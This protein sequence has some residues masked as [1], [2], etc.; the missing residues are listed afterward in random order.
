MEKVV[1]YEQRRRIRAQ[2]RVAKKKVETEETTKLTKTM[3][4]STIKVTKTKSPERLA[5]RSPERSPMS[6]KPHSPDR[7]PKPTKMTSPERQHKPAP[8]KSTSPQRH[9]Q[10]NST[11]PHIND[12]I[13][14]QSSPLINGHLNEDNE[15][16]K[17]K[18]PRGQSPEKQ[19]IQSTTKATRPS[20][21]EKRRPVSPS[22]PITPK[23]KSHRFSEYASA[24]M[25]R[26]GLKESDKINKYHESNFKKVS[27]ADEVKT[28]K[29]ETSCV[30]ET[31]RV[32][33]I[34]DRTS[35][36]DVIEVQ[37]NGKQSPSPDRSRRLSDSLDSTQQPRKQSPER[38]S[39]VEITTEVHTSSTRKPSPTRQNP[40]RQPGASRS[41]SPD[42]KKMSKKETT[43]KKI[44]QKQEEKPSWVTSRNLKKVTSES[45]TFSSKKIET[46]KPKYR[47][48]SPSKV[49]S[50]P[51]DV[52]T[53]SYG[54]G[55]LDAEGRPLFG[56]KALRKG[57]TNY[58]GM[59]SSILQNYLH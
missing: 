21:P 58:Q 54:P 16:F 43:T 47:A 42:T 9:T 29:I 18:A 7:K 27:P 3:R 44:P 20:S 8:Y 36:K 50:K 46:E 6:Q 23:T 19:N 14:S 15:T 52:I 35:S 49:I 48:T 12:K 57:A 11:S 41:P 51:I 4:Q 45:R 31:H 25:K 1:G 5:H 2:I 34:I 28:K 39:T 55:P 22:K 13:E 24:Y 40:V 33:T 17:G 26:V 56:I 10:S 32:K 38:K 30:A 53:S 59:L 37:V